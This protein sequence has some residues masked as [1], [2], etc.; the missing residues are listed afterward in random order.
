MCR[1][2]HYFYF[3]AILVERKRGFL[4]M[5]MIVRFGGEVIYYEPIN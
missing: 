5:K 4:L 2:I 1:K 3:L